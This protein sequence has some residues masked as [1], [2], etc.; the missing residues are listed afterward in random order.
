MR[1]GTWNIQGM[2]TKETEVMRE[3]DKMNMDIV[4]L[5]ETKKKSKGIEK[6]GNYMHI[7]SGIPKEERARGCD[8][9]KREI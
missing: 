3:I 7:F 4:V 8:T 9:H 5:S 1:F 6:K 2:R